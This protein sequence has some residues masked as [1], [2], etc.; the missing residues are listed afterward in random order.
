MIRGKLLKHFLMLLISF[1]FF[2]KYYSLYGTQMKEEVFDNFKANDE[3]E[4]TISPVTEDGSTDRKGNP[5][6]KAKTGGWN[7][8]VL[9][10]GNLPL[11]TILHYY[12]KSITYKFYFYCCNA[13]SFG[14]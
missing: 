1:I 13:N 9:L 12:L 11:A 4:M 2:L 7:S 14:V 10:L 3:T 8:A 5:A 6:R